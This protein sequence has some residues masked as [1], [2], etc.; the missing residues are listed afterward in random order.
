MSF[1][2]Y[3]ES[4]INNGRFAKFMNPYPNELFMGFEYEIDDG[5]KKHIFTD[6][7]NSKKT[8]SRNPPWTK[9]PTNYLVVEDYYKFEVQSPVAPLRIHRLQIRSFLNNTKF[10]TKSS[11][12]KNSGGIHINVER[13]NFTTRVSNNVF[14]FLHNPVYYD[15]FQKLSHRCSDSMIRWASNVKTLN[16]FRNPEYQIKLEHLYSNTIWGN[17]NLI[18]TAHKS[19]A[20]ELRLF[21]ALPHLLIPALEM[22]ESLFHAADHVEAELNWD[23]WREYVNKPRYKN[24]HNLLTS[25]GL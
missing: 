18:I 2:L 11:E 8:F 17:K 13:N 19:Y 22:G 1:N 23:N 7:G 12:N 14:Q 15:K 3:N 5:V 25:L 10:N 20:F 6:T 4:N 16:K 24:L 21:K 9:L